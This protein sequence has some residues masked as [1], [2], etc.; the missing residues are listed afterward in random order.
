MA[1]TNANGERPAVLVTADRVEEANFTLRRFL[2]GYD[3]DEVD[4]FLDEVIA[5]FR[6]YEATR[7]HL[8][9]KLINLKG[10]GASKVNTGLTEAVK[11]LTGELVIKE[12]ASGEE[13]GPQH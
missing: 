2:P 12:V 9:D 7:D 11:I 5:T 1:A 13:A 8:V 3:E 10:K 6:Y 4:D